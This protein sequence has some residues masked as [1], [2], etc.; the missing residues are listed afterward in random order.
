MTMH[1]DPARARSYLRLVHDRDKR[2]HRRATVL[3]F[4]IAPPRVVEP[5]PTPVET[6]W[7]TAVEW[8]GLVIAVGVI[9]LG[10]GVTW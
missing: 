2:P 3:Q 9:L 8:V 5:A 10:G 4:P 6:R 1:S 7:P